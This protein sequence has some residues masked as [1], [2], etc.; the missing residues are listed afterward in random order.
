MGCLDQKS[1]LPSVTERD[2]IFDKLQN[3]HI[4]K[5]VYNR[6][7]F[8]RHMSRNHF[9]RDTVQNFHNNNF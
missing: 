2:M 1:F 9:F 5:Y 7:Y 4:I 3:T 6:Q 8:F